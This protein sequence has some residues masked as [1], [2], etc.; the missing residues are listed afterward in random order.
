MAPVLRALLELHFDRC[1]RPLNARAR[2]SG[3]PHGDDHLFA[4]VSTPEREARRHSLIKFGSI[5]FLHC[6]RRWGW[7]IPVLRRS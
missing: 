3:S 2:P 4:G 7:P 6:R 5:C 1:H